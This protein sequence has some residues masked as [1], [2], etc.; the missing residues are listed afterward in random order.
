MKETKKTSTR[1]PARKPLHDTREGWLKAAVARLE[2][3]FI[4][5]STLGLKMPKTL[6]VTCGFPRGNAVKVIG[7]HWGG[8][9]AVDGKT[10]HICVKGLTPPEPDATY[11][12]LVQA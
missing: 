9:L 4:K 8:G 2:A 11:L 10:T 3:E 5:P 6:L 7:M 12:D 1:R